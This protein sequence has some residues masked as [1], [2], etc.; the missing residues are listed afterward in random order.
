MTRSPFSGLAALLVF[1]LAPLLIRPVLAQTP[2]PQA[3]KEV[4]NSIGMKLVLIPAGK[5]TMG[6]P[7]KEEERKAVPKGRKR[8]YSERQHKVEITRP[9]YMGVYTVTQAQFRKFKAKHVSYFSAQGDGKAKVD[10]LDTS[11]FPVESVTWEEARDFCEWLTEQDKKKGFNR[12]YRLPTEAEWEYACRAGA[13]SYHPFHFGDRLSSRQANFDG[14]FPYGGAD[15]G[16]F[17]E[18]TTTVGS[19]RPN[20]VG[21]YD[22]HGNVLQWC[23]D[24]YDSDYYKDS[25]LKDPKGPESGEYRVIRGGAFN[26]DG[27]SCRSASRGKSEPGSR[28]YPTGFRVVCSSPARTP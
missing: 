11:H 28:I 25:P 8:H 19:Y 16:P 22:M 5:F 18:R 2:K 23:Q 4:I 12:L 6:S 24:W 26:L 17:L 3:P 9:F 7:K 15:K 14:R 10:G 13:P 27:G 21:L 1:I 20:A